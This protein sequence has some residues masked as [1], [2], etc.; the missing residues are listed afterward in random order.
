MIKFL[1][2]VAEKHTKRQIS[3]V[4]EIEAMSLYHACDLLEIMSGITIDGVSNYADLCE[5][6]K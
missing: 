6:E 1:G 5:M 3:R 2:C 4:F